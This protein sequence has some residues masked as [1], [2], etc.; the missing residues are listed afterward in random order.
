MLRAFVDGAYVWRW[1]EWFA[2]QQLP[3]SF[4]LWGPGVGLDYGTYGKAMVSVNVGF[5]VGDNPNLP[6]GYD[7]DGL[8][9][10]VRVWLTGKVWL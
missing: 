9:P 2:D 10:S 4:G 8:N 5:P 7:A 1:T 3:A 6:T